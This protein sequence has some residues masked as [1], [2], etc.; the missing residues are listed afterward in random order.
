MNRRVLLQGS[1]AAAAGALTGTVSGK[2]SPRIL[3]VFF[4]RAGENYAPGKYEMLEVGH[5]ERMARMIAERTGAELLKVEPVR[6]Y[7]AGYRETTEVAQAEKTAQARPPVATPQ[8]DWARCDVVFIGHPIWWG[9]MPMPMRTFSTARS[10]PGRRSSTSR[11]TRDRDLASPRRP[12]GTTPRAHARS[13]GSP[14]AGA[15]SP[16]RAPASR[17]GSAASASEQRQ[18]SS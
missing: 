11:P 15:R 10:S 4:S 9:E 3:I 17:P 14:S 6:A 13:R 8:P 12:S 2:E 7:P 18:R 16:D 5:T 1:A